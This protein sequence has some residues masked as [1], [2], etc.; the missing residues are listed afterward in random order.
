MG[1]LFQRSRGN[2]N[3]PPWNLQDLK[4]NLFSFQ[5]LLLLPDLFS[6]PENILFD[7]PHSHGGC[8]FG[9]FIAIILGRQPL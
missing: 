4:L 9:H 7:C 5:Q 8:F 6:R 3:T 2:S 1:L